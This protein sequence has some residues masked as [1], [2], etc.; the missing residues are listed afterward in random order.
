MTAIIMV[1]DDKG[2]MVM[3]GDRQVSSRGFITKTQP[4]IMNKEGVFLV[5]SSGYLKGLN[6]IEH[7]DIPPEI[8]SQDPDQYIMVQLTGA[9]RYAFRS[10]GQLEDDHGMENTYQTFVVAYKGRFYEIGGDLSVNKV[11]KD[12]TATG[13]GREL[14]TGAL[15]ALDDVDVPIEEKA[16]RAIRAAAEYDAGVSH[17]FDLIIWKE[18]KE[19]IHIEYEN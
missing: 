16:L 10:S 13:S 3:A 9:L 17:P 11:Q 12:F 19:P 7:M 2:N 14:A 15:Y 6:I 4:K 18:G 1:K 5:G 8:V